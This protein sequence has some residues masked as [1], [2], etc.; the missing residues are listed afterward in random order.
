MRSG[1]WDPSVQVE[2]S[3]LPS[4]GEMIRDQM[5]S[6]KPAETQAEMLERYRETLY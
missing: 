2:R 3:S 5:K 1:L 4:I 6:D